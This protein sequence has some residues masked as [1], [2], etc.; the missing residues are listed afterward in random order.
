[1]FFDPGL[2]NDTIIANRM[3]SEKAL[4]RSSV[5]NDLE[6][7]SRNALGADQRQQRSDQRSRCGGTLRIL[8]KKGNQVRWNDSMRGRLSPCDERYQ[9]DKNNELP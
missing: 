6:L 8:H 7:K 5:I 2:A 3:A 1:M 4:F 9:H